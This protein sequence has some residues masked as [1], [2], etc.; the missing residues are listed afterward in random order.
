VRS[1]DILLSP[2]AEEYKVSTLRKLNVMELMSQKNNVDEYLAVSE[3]ID[4]DSETI[5]KIAASLSDNVNSDVQLAQKLYEYVRDHISHSFDI[6]SDVVTCKA[7]DV[8]EAKEG[9]CYAKS[10]LLAALLR[11]LKIP[12]G[13]CYQKLVLDDSEPSYLTLHGLNAIY[14]E[15]LQKWIRVDA[16]GNKEGVNAEFSLDKEVLAFPV[17]TNL[18]EVDYPMI[19]AQPNGKVVKAL[20][21]SNSRKEL[22]KNLPNDF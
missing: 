3:I 16:R 15:S 6:D 18:G 10:H 11:C 12:T 1:P 9:I 2:V 8:L 19:Y 22:L 13:F 17:R 4:Y 7:S 14:L 20:Q 5:Q 21:T